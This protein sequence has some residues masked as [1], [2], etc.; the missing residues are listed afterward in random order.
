M[1]YEDIVEK[2]SITSYFARKCYS[3]ILKGRITF[4]ELVVI[5]IYNV[6][7]DVYLSTALEMNNLIDLIAWNNYQVLGKD[8]R[9]ASWQQSY[10][11]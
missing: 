2:T 7:R 1:Y 8:N 10:G 4:Q 11:Q 5:N 9:A 6:Y 3:D